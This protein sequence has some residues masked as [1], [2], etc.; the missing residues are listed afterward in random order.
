MTK[1]SIFPK[2]TCL[3]LAVFLKFMLKQKEKR[4][5]TLPKTFHFL[6]Q[7]I[8]YFIKEKVV[9]LENNCP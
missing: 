6:F 1:F 9:F 5:F 4:G 3:L 8:R 2:S 7:N